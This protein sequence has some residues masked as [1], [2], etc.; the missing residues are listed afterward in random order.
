MRRRC[1]RRTAAQLLA[2]LL[3]L[4][5]QVSSHR[6]CCWAQAAATTRASPQGAS[7]SNHLQQL[8][9]SLDS[10]QDGQLRKQELRLLVSRLSPEYTA[11]SSTLDAAVE[12]VIGR[13]DSP[14]VGLGVSQLELEQHLH[15]LL[16]VR[17]FCVHGS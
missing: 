11:S 10:D 4:C 9:D 12:G 13:L 14:D 3:L 16:Q 1:V 8:F 7:S 17:H 5:L 6:S 2:L 15:T